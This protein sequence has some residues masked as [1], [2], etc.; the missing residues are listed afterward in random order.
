MGLCAGGCEGGVWVLVSGVGFVGMMAEGGVRVWCCVRE[1]VGVKGGGTG[2]WFGW[3][4]VG[5]GVMCRR[6][7]GNPEEPVRKRR[8]A[9]YD[10]YDWSGDSQRPALPRPILLTC[11]KCCQRPSSAWV[12]ISSTGQPK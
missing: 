11:R 7:K 3:V 2:M 12:H 6:E 4:V 1:E 5:S 9:D 10:A 8:N